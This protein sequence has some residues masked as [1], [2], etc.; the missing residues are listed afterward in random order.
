LVLAHLPLLVL[1]LAGGCVKGKPHTGDTSQLDTAASICETIEN[2]QVI[3]DPLVNCDSVY[4]FNGVAVACEG[5]VLA[6]SL[7]GSV[8]EGQWP[9]FYLNLPV[10]TAGYNY[11]SVSARGVTGD[12]RMKVELYDAAGALV[13]N[14]V[15]VPLSD[16]TFSAGLLSL[17]GASGISKI[18]FVAQPPSASGAWW[19]EIENISLLACAE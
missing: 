2:T 7:T 8:P 3:F 15:F 6:A 1:G 16:A 10:S 9:G 13:Q 11:F 17:Y 12:Q 5:E 19:A 18:Q 4:G 14:N